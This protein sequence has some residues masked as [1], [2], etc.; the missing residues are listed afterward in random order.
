MIRPLDRPLGSSSPILP[1]AL[2]R[3]IILIVAI[4]IATLFVI[5]QIF[6]PGT[7]SHA[8]AGTVAQHLLSSKLPGDSDGSR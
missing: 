2:R 8:D 5:A 4:K 1:R 6:F 7:G 3:D